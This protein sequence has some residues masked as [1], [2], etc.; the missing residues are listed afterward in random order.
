MTSKYPA[1][2]A[3]LALLLGSCTSPGGATAPPA[4]AAPAATSAATSPALAIVPATSATVVSPTAVPTAS[5]PHGLERTVAATVGAKRHWYLVPDGLETPD[6]LSFTSATILA[7]FEG[8]PTIGAPFAR[9]RA[10]GREYPLVGPTTGPTFFQA[11]VPLQGLTPGRYLVDVLERLTGGREAVVGTA[12]FM[13]SAPEYA[14]WT[15]DF[16]G[17]ESADPELANTAAI[18]DGLRVPMVVMW[19]PR[20]WATADVRPERAAA[21]LAWTRERAAK[22]DEVALHLHGWLDWIRAAGV[23]PRVTPSWAGRRDGYDVPLSAY[24]EDETRA[25]LEAALRQMAEHGLP[26]PTSFRA[27]GHF[28]S[29]PNLRALAAT[30][31]TADCS[32]VPAGSFGTLRL[33]W[34]LPRDAQPYFPSGDDPSKPGDLPLLESPT[35]GG[36]TYGHTATSI[37]AIVRT[38]LGILAPAGEVARERRA[39]NIVSHPGTIVPAE[40]AAI[41]KLLGA[42]APLRYDRD[43]GPLRFVTLQ[44]LARAY[45]P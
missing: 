25:L 40:R 35:I 12:E 32:A 7:Q 10:T 34:T 30:G 5:P 9:L 22:G 13:L 1:W 18:A 20:V 6:G 24:P 14:V 39:L 37:E 41:E 23:A 8:D 16:E 27:G 15:L 33:P 38:D 28:A 29:A 21:M 4:G 3:A 19:N 43:A 44:Q 2:A 45:A 31:F 11:A 26:R 42:L 36:N 17:D